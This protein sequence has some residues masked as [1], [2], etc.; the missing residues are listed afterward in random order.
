MGGIRGRYRKF[1]NVW[2]KTVDL[3][4]QSIMLRQLLQDGFSESLV[5]GYAVFLCVNSLSVAAGIL[6][7]NL[8]ALSEILI[9]SIFVMIAAV[10]YPILVL[11]HSYNNF[12]FDRDLF[13][14][15]IE[16][17]PPGSFECSARLFVDPAERELFIA[18]LNSLRILS[19][20]DLLLRVSMNLAF[21]HRF[22][23]IIN[24]MVETTVM[25]KSRRSRRTSTLQ[26]PVYVVDLYGN[27]STAGLGEGLETA[28][29]PTH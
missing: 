23:T 17:L 26:P 24:L 7:G 16:V 2:Q 3:T 22:V 10:F 19:L 4:M 28:T 1:W 29:V 13:N 21:C 12:D 14:V 18:S 15:Y 9:D 6:L 11:V 5:M 27:R 20:T 25:E 8:S